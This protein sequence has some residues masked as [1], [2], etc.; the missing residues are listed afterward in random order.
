[1][2]YEIRM[3]FTSWRREENSLSNTKKLRHSGI[4]TENSKQNYFLPF[5]SIV[6]KV[7]EN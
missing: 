5:F 1:M 7:K 6:K 3:D 2:P 4:K